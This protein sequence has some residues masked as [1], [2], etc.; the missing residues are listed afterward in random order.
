MKLGIIAGNRS[1]PILLARRIKEENKDIQVSAFCFKGETHP[2]IVEF[3]DS[4]LWFKVGQLAGLAEAIESRGFKDCIMAGQISPLRIFQRKHWD[5]ELFSLIRDANDFRPHTIFQ[6]IIG[7]LEARGVNFLDSTA[8]LKQDLAGEGPLNGLEPSESLERDIG[9][10]LR[11]I[12]KFVELDVGQTIAVK[13]GGVIALESLEG[14]DHTIR[15]AYRLGGK[16]CAVLK[17]SKANQD[18]RFDV[19]VVGLATLR[20]LKRIKAAGLVLEKDK[21]I[22]LQKPLFLSRAKEAKIPVIGKSLPSG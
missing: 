11:V 19:P 4:A 15:R 3:V 1:L 17:F 22:I 6:K 2:G 9:L 10:G 8:Y 20:L 12:S 14:T 13:Q 18:L 21:V 16:G 5:K 7:Y